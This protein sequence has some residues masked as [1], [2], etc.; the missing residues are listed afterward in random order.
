MFAPSPEIQIFVA[1][2]V[3]IHAQVICHSTSLFLC[4]DDNQVLCWQSRL[5]QRLTVECETCRTSMGT[6]PRWI[7]ILNSGSLLLSD[8]RRH[9]C[10]LSVSN[11]H[12]LYWPYGVLTSIHWTADRCTDNHARR[13]GFVWSRLRAS[14]WGDGWTI[15]DKDVIPCLCF[16]VSS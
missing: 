15:V 7:I 3:P 1:K 4:M 10:V 9:R 6:I 12:R 13:P 11:G 14:W 16:F 8:P 5:Y 2:G